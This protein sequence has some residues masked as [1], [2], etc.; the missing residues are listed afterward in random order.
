[1]RDLLFRPYPWQDYDWGQRL[2]A[3]GCLLALALLI[4][5]IRYAW[6]TRGG[7]LRRTA[8]LLYP[9]LMM[10]IAFSLSVGNAGTGFRYRAHL[11]I[12]AIGILSILWATSGATA[13]VRKRA[14]GLAT[15]GRGEMLPSV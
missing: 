15:G 13:V 10:L 1:V 8:P 11:L 2:G 14:H 9:T 3:I 5:L 4:A 6:L 7:I 12:P